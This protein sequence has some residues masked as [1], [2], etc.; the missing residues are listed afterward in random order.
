MNNS[1]PATAVI[2]G[3]LPLLRQFS[4]TGIPTVTI[5]RSANALCTYSRYY[6]S[7]GMTMDDLKADAS[8]FLERLIELAKSFPV[9]PV[10]YYGDDTALF[11]LIKNREV[12]AQ[13]YHF[14]LPDQDILE[15][16]SDKMDFARLAFEKDLPVPAGMVA[17]ASLDCTEIDERI[18]FPCVFKPGSHLGWFESE[19]VKSISDMPQKVLLANDRRECERALKG[20][21]DFTDKFVVQEFVPGGEDEI[22]SFHTYVSQE[23]IAVASYVGKKVRTYPA[24]GGESSY[25]KL[26]RNDR[27]TQLGLEVVEKL[28]IIGVMK[29][30]FKKDSS[31]DRYYVLEIN[32]RFNLWNYLGARAGIN[33]A[34]LAYQDLCGLPMTVTD[35]YRDDLH[36]LDL[37]R[38]L[39]SFIKD[40]WPSG[41]LSIMQWLRSLARPKVY[42]LFEWS[43]PK[44]FLFNTL[45]YLKR[46]MKKYLLPSRRRGN[47]V[48]NSD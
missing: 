29:I 8:S 33:L 26:V 32:L 14:S 10:L 22:Y 18:G 17:D 47:K 41:Q 48:A 16:C 39:S 4:N 40:Y 15:A 28:G 12:L 3:G 31:R 1:P 6:R 25:V 42:S 9:P 43:D 5:P 30:D 11:F 38:D 21:R 20:I 2:L 35:V 36:W 7:A 24:M 34:E 46:G 13:Y 45:I 37:G 44:P 23:R 19:I 27:V